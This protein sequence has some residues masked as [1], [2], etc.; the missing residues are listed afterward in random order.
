MEYSNNPLLMPINKLSRM[1]SAD[2]SPVGGSQL[3]SRLSTILQ[4]LQKRNIVTEAPASPRLQK[5]RRRS[6]YSEAVVA[7]MGVTGA[8]K[9]SFIRRVTA[10][11]EVHVG[12]SLR[13]SLFC[14]FV[15]I[16]VVYREN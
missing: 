15:R 3:G 14:P 10:N 5:P 12:D 16:L 13:S 11:E 1:A 9:S 6:L 2:L 7:V 8:G 4:E